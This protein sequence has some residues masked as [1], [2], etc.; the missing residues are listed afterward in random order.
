MK[1]KKEIEDRIKQFKELKRKY[2]DSD[3]FAQGLSQLEWVIV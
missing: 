2:P 3:C 1:T